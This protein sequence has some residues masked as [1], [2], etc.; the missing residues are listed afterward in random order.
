[1]MVLMVINNGLDGDDGLEGDDG[2]DGDDGDVGEDE[3]LVPSSLRKH[4]DSQAV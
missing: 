4:G 3:L 2:D 1:M